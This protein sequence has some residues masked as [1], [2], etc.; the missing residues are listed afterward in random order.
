MSFL[1]GA[2]HFLHKLHMATTPSLRN[3][4][5][6]RINQSSRIE[7][8]S[9]SGGSMT[10]EAAVVLPLFLFFFINLSSSLD[11]IMLHSDLEYALHGAGNELCLYGC[12][13]TDDMKNLG[14]AGHTGPADGSADAAEESDGSGE[15]AGSASGIALSYTYVKYRMEE[16]LGD[17]YLRGSPLRN[18]PLSLDFLGSSIG[19]DSDIVDIK[20]SYSVKT[21]IDSVG[22]P[23]MFMAGRFYGHMWNGYEISGTSQELSQERIVY[24]TSDSE[25]YHLTPACTHLKLSVRSACYL[26]LEDE[27]NNSGGRYYPCAVF[28]HGEVPETIYLAAEGDRYHYDFNCYT[29][30]RNYSPVPLS[31]VEDSRRPCSRCGGG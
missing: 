1:C 3:P 9:L 22:I 17:G 5:P 11:M 27:R 20:L 7:K 25:V 2:T 18:G 21:P 29:L 26:G 6:G 13:L 31:E 8:T 28:A 24:I 14:P 16:D 4:S 19:K 12:L 23:L 10:V 15:I 30:T